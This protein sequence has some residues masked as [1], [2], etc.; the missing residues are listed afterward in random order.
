MRIGV[1]PGTFDPI[2]YGHLDIIKRASRLFDHLYVAILVNPHKTPLFSVEERR[3]MLEAE[4]RGLDRVS[5]ETFRGLSIEYAKQKN[6][7]AIV[8]GLRAVTDFE[9][10]FKLAAMNRNLEGSIETVFMM[11]SSE[12]SFL[13]SSAVKEVAEFGGNVSKWV[14]PS[15]AALL[16]DKFKNGE[17]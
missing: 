10:E 4:L 7:I 8:R 15:V 9:F 12:Y 17:R 14:S 16:S 5:V 11:T 6:A 13:S 3:I 2:T 1:C